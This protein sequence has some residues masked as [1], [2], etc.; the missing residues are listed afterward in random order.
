M[1]L[2]LADGAAE[3]SRSPPAHHRH[4]CW[5]AVSEEQREEILR[6]QVVP[7]EW[8]GDRQDCVPVKTSIAMAVTAWQQASRSN[9]DETPPFVLTFTLSLGRFHRWIDTEMMKKCP[10][11]VGGYRIYQDVNLAEVDPQWTF[12]HT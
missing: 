3:R 4:Q 11:R 12:H 2:A 10:P 9:R 1:A 5:I 7:R 8:F 6:T